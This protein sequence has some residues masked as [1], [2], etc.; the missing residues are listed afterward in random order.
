M[1]SD[2]PR[3]ELVEP[4]LVLLLLHITFY[5]AKTQ[6]ITIWKVSSLESTSKT[7]IVFRNKWYRSA[8]SERGHVSRF[9]RKSS[10][11]LIC[12]ANIKPSL[13]TMTATLCPT[14]RRSYFLCK[15]SE[16][17]VPSW[18]DDTRSPCPQSLRGAHGS[19]SKQST[20]LPKWMN[21]FPGR[22]H[23]ILRWH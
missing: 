16:S 22:H 21:K 14:R 11:V 1:S 18:Y 8:C 23:Q 5:V 19:A 9:A 10:P 4:R 12:S 7:R 15:L 2:E 3:L 6:Y 13:Q 20:F 17:R